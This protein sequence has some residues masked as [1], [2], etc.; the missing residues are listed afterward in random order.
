MS[1]LVSKKEEL[2]TQLNVLESRSRSLSIR[3][4]QELKRVWAKYF[5]PI[6][7]D[8]I[9]FNHQG[10]EVKTPDSKWSFMQLWSR[11][12][13][14]EGGDY[15]EITDIEVVVSR[16]DGS[17]KSSDGQWIVDRFDRIS[18]YSQML[19]DF[20][21]DIMAELNSVEE[22][23]GKFQYHM[24]ELRK[25]V[26]EEHNMIDVKISE[27]EKEETIKKL[28]TEGIELVQP[29]EE[30][31]KYWSNGPRIDLKFNW[32][33]SN[34][35]KLKV[36]KMSASGKSCDVEVHTSSYYGKDGVPALFE[37]RVR[38]ENVQD[39]INNYRK[40]IVK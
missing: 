3:R 1:D 34:V 31:D 18:K 23:Y 10:I 16:F 30:K 15:E 22:R 7:D 21:D 9:E 17:T 26:R 32:S 8:V 20:K 25:P 37:K 5:S 33:M 35:D 39:F 28:T 2:R 19:V 27:I 14:V 11:S 29:E 36:T 38:F 13:W 12:E 6:G 4:R 40:W 24:Y